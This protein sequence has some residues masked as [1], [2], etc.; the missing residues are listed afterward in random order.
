MQIR[1]EAREA[2]V[3]IMRAIEESEALP[4]GA[5]AFVVLVMAHKA[6]GAVTVCSASLPPQ[7]PPT[8]V[9]AF[10]G[11]A[12]AIDDGLTNV[13]IASTKRGGEPPTGHE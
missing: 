6:D 3:G 7:D 12:R 11:A 9:S 4:D 10:V 13:V 2:I 5:A 1:G 8:M